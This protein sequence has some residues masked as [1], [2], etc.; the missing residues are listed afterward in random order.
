MMCATFILMSGVI[1]IDKKFPMRL[2]LE[3]LP[4]VH[5]SEEITRGAHEVYF[6]SRA[7]D[8]VI[9]VLTYVLLLLTY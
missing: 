3:V 6:N 8:L 4:G 5:F 1:Y 9:Y 2:V 7:L